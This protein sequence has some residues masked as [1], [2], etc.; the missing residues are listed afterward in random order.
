MLLFHF[1]LKWLSTSHVF[2]GLKFDSI[3]FGILLWKIVKP[4]TNNEIEPPIRKIYQKYKPIRYYFGMPRKQLSC[5]FVN[6]LTTIIT[7]YL[8]KRIKNAITWKPLLRRKSSF[9]SKLNLPVAITSS[10]TKI[11]EVIVNLGSYCFDIL[12]I[13]LILQERGS[14]YAILRCWKEAKN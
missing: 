2:T 5:T 14:G 3:Y 12:V 7:R 6:K 1:R 9:L 13:N 8:D 11:K 10:Y 4:R